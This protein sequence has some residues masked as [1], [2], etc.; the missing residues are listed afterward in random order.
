MPTIA[1]AIEALEGEI[2]SALTRQAEVS[3][4]GSAASSQ[5]TEITRAVAELQQGLRRA[6]EIKARAEARDIEATTL[7]NAYF[8]AIEPARTLVTSGALDQAHFDAEIEAVRTELGLAD[9]AAVQACSTWS[10]P[11]TT[12]PPRG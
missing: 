3:A 8:G 4:T 1:K 2:G 7:I 11:T 6:N 9:A 12:T 10:R 5:L